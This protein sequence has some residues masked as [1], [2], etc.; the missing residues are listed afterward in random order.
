MICSEYFI[1]KNKGD[2]VDRQ[3]VCFIG[4]FGQTVLIGLFALY[5]H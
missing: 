2:V 4:R 1:K 5:V 3:T